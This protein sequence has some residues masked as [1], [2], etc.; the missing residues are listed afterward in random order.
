MLLLLLLLFALESILVIMA[1]VVFQQTSFVCVG[2]F[3]IFSCSNSATGLI[4]SVVERVHRAA[5]TTSSLCK[6]FARVKRSPESWRFFGDLARK[7]M[8][9]EGRGREEW[10]KNNK[11]FFALSYASPVQ[12]GREEKK[13]I[14]KESK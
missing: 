13:I 7:G 4:A 6:L 1:L 10:K 3:F 5:T 9:S 14:K 11:F 2:S 12:R 8:G